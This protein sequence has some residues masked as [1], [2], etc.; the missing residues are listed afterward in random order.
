MCGTDAKDSGSL[1]R[2][3]RS[4]CPKGPGAAFLEETGIRQVWELRNV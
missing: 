2:R 3:K 1:E 4:V